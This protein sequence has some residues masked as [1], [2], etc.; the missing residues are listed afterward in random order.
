M[1]GRQ[2]HANNLKQILL[3]VHNYMDQEGS[4]P[5]F[6]NIGSDGQPKLS[7]RVA[8]LPYLG[9]E[10]LYNQFDRDQPWDSPHNKSLLSAMPAIYA[11]P[12]ESPREGITRYRGFQGKGAAFDGVK[13]IRIADLTDG[14]SYTAM[15]AIARDAVPWTK[16]D[17]LLFAD[18][19][20]LPQL[21][22]S[23][24]D[25]Y[26]LGLLD[27]SVRIL[28]R[29]LAQFPI[30]L[31]AVITISAGEVIPGDIFL[32]SG[33]I[34]DAAVPTAVGT[35]PPITSVGAGGGAGIVSG[36]QPGASG[37][38]RGGPGAM[39]GG[40][41]MMS[42]MRG[43]GSS[44]GMMGGMASAAAGGAGMSPV[45]VERRLQAIEQ[46]LDLLIQKLDAVNR[47]PGG[48]PAP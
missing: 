32:E 4:L 2:V 21:D 27:G 42:G 8:L 6:A 1:Q 34:Q 11:G 39:G 48:A 26:P 37:G 41:S 33:L 15:V 22:E 29:G 31:R 20:P 43:A 40:R 38:S 47:T 3:A 19:S 36:G 45:D 24:P 17:E 23:D 18:K 7:W 46:K 30:W 13:S 16:P 25:G 5:M 44:G 12:G 28:R 9:E 10:K 14:M 35:T